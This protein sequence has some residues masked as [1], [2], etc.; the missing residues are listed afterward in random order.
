MNAYVDAFG[1]YFEGIDIVGAILLWKILIQF[2]PIF[3]PENKAL[4]K[5]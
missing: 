1:G 4:E 3:K 5:Y 2:D